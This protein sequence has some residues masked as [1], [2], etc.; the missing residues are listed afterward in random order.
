MIKTLTVKNFRCFEESVVSFQDISILVG[1]NN[2]GKSTLID[3]LKIIATVVRKYK[4]LHFVAPPEWVTGEVDNGVCP[5]VE[6]Q[7]ISDKGIFNMYGPPPAIVEAVF[8]NGCSIRAY[9]GENL[10]VFALIKN[11]DGRIARNSKDAKLIEIPP[12]EVLPQ[13]SALLET[14]KVV[15]RRTVE[16]N[17]TTRLTSRNF[18]NQLYYNRDLFGRFKD[19]VESTWEALQVKPVEATYGEA[20]PPLQ[21]Y[22]RNNNFEAEIGWMGHGL[23]MWVQC[24]WFLSQCGENAIVILDEPDVYMHADLQRRLIRL[25]APMFSQLIVATHSIEIMEE[26]LPENIIPVDYR[27]KRIKSVG[28][29]ALLQE[30]VEGMGSSFNLDLARLFVSRRFMIWEG[31]DSD[32]ALLSKFQAV[33]YPQELHSI[34]SF[35]KTFVEGWG[36]WQRALAVAEVFR[37]NQVHVKCYCIFDSDY[38][39]KDEIARRQQEAK[40]KH[41]NLHIWARKEIENY[42]IHPDVILRLIQAKKR[43]GKI[44]KEILENMMRKIADEMRTEVL[45]C[46][47]SSILENDKKLSFKTTHQLAENRLVELWRTPFC[48]VPGKDFI[49]KLATWTA[50]EYGFTFQALNVVSYFKPE[51]VPF[52][53]KDVI[54]RI[55]EGRSFM[56][57]L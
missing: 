7:N 37:T 27:R 21:F 24:M 12:I 53:I 9:I 2:A 50:T 45:D 55:V 46:I 5:T 34:S 47:A 57:E 20:G 32:R 39:L 54:R 10:S 35:P 17:K 6:N 15:E 43:K 4:K 38:H 44:S 30:M 8:S 18:R 48:A 19:L 1:R 26:V 22:V 41:I 56:D 25:I 49:K 42:V 11:S 29:H 13:I 23:Q 36:G 51:E 52:E 28:S 31:K 40:E 33:L 14:E 3:V 16:Q